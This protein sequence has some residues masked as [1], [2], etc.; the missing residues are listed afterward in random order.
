MSRGGAA[1]W[2][3]PTRPALLIM[4]GLSAAPAPVSGSLFS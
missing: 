1:G 2:N 3:M 4:G